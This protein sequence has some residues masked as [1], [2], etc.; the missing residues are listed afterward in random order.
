V[1][2]LVRRHQISERRACRLV[3]QHRSTQRYQAMLP[4]QEL[5]LSRP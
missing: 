3:G 2:Y 4:A 1:A 5:Q